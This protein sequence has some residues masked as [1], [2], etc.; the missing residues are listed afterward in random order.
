MMLCRRLSAIPGLPDDGRHL[1]S[2]TSRAHGRYSRSVALVARRMTQPVCR[3][4]PTTHGLATQIVTVSLLRDDT[5]IIVH[6]DTDP[7]LTLAN[8]MLV[9][10]MGPG[11]H[12]SGAP[13]CWCVCADATKNPSKI[14]RSPRLRPSECVPPARRVGLHD[15][16]PWSHARAAAPHL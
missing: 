4:W 12:Q 9:G 3:R 7:L 8:L 2:E 15:L 16:R 13:P 6:G 10:R 1:R 11:N 14:S 5:R